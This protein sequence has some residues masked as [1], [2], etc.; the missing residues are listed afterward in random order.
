MKELVIF[1]TNNQEGIMSKSKKFYPASY[2]EE[3]IK[4]DL[5]KVR[6]KIGEKY[7]FDGKKILQPTQKDVDFIEDYPDGA[8]KKVSEINLDVADLWEEKIPCDILILT[9][10]D[11]KIVVGHRMADC[12]VLIIEDRAQQVVAVSHC[13]A[14]QINRKVP[15]YTEE[16]LLK[17]Y[18]SKKENLYA[19][20]GSCIK[21]DNYIYDCYPKWA[22]NKDVWEGCL[23]K[24]NNLYSIDLVTA[25]TNQ[26]NIDKN[27]I[28]ISPIDTYKDPKY[29]SHTSEVRKEQKPLG[30]NFVGAF[31]QEQR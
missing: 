13:G 4:N 3:D 1:E 16:A 29:Y 8:F 22:T 2:T 28:T 30:Q 14:S 10:T 21:K 23:T 15:F 6:E 7:N 31:Y 17:E 9:A 27:H 24:D 5:L 19:Y 26:L 12:P 18:N 25:I 11:P 20:I